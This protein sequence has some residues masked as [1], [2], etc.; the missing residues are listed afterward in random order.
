MAELARTAETVHTIAIILFC[1]F[2][3]EQYLAHNLGRA[4]D[5]VPPEQEEPRK[6][7]CE[8]RHAENL[9]Q[10]LQSESSEMHKTSRLL[11]GGGGGGGGRVNVI[12]S[13]LTGGVGEVE[14]TCRA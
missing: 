2:D 9:F 5:A 13:A 12:C 4:S 3:L 10:P 14:E 1:S 6:T 7:L 8:V 11:G